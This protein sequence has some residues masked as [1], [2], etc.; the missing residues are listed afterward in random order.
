MQIHV[1]FLSTHPIEWYQK[2]TGSGK[3]EFLEIKRSWG[4][5]DVPYQCWFQDYSWYKRSEVG[6]GTPRKSSVPDDSEAGP[7]TTIWN[8]TATN[9]LQSRSLKSIYTSS[10]LENRWGHGA[11]NFHYKW[12]R[13]QQ[14]HLAAGSSCPKWAQK[15]E[16]THGWI[17]EKSSGRHHVG[18]NT[19][20]FRQS[21]WTISSMIL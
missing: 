9:H 14:T 2:C 3:T 15:A 5:Q 20:S 8:T 10:H 19:P 7:V 17:L 13:F 1:D 21:G 11:P 18:D 6:L 16:P 4:H 12:G